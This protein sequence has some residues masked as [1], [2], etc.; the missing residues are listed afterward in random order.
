MERYDGRNDGKT[1]RASLRALRLLAA[2]PAVQLVDRPLSTLAPLIADGYAEIVGRWDEVA[3]GKTWHCER[4]AITD[5]GRTFL[6]TL[7]QG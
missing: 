5:A 4:V 1:Y 3:N 6:A 2:K 7:E